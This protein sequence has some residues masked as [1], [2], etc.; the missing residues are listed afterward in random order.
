VTSLYLGRTATPMQEE[1]HR[2]AGQDYQ[3]DRL[4]QPEDVA[5]SV[6]SI[7]SLPETAEVT[8]VHIRPMRPA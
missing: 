5:Q 6:L 4:L 2:L 1:I 3:P 8:D 7:L